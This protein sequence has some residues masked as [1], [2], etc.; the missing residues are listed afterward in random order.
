MA[1]SGDAM[2][3]ANEAVNVF[4]MKSLRVF[5]SMICYL[6]VLN[7]NDAIVNHCIIITYDIAELLFSVTIFL[8][9]FYL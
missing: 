3:T 4:L 2:A 6:W 7:N 1:A 5:V 9:K 8:Q